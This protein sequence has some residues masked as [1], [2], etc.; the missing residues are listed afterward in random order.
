MQ[1]SSEHT[2]P[3]N[4][5]EG[6]CC[7]VWN[8]SKLCAI[9][10]T[11]PKSSLRSETRLCP[12]T[13]ICAVSMTSTGFVK[14]AAG[15]SRHVYYLNAWEFFMLWECVPLPK[16]EESAGKRGPQNTDAEQRCISQR[17]NS[18]GVP[19]SIS[20]PGNEYRP[21]LAAESDDVI[22]SVQASQGLPITV[23]GGT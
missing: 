13:C 2:C 8:P 10:Q 20:L 6:Y 1:S 7:D 21:N 23:S 18:K 12:S 14:G 3:K 5:Q 19:L 11:S 16:P 4:F 17:T 15:F 9:D 22:F